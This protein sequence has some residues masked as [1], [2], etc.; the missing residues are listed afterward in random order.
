MAG[1]P[2]FTSRT[3]TRVDSLLS[4]LFAFNTKYHRT[5]MF[6]RFGP[7]GIDLVLKKP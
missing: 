5:G 4:R 6:D 3:A 7:S 1:K 2:A